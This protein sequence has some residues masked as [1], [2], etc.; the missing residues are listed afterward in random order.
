LVGVDDCVD[1]S[2]AVVG[3]EFGLGEGVLFEVAEEAGGVGDSVLG[4]LAGWVVA[5]G[6]E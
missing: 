3:P 5:V 1:G 4:G 6:F 2:F